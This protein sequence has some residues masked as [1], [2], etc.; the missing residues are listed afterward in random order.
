MK[1]IKIVLLIC[2]TAM[3]MACGSSSSITKTT[4]QEYATTNPN[5]VEIFMS[6]KPSKKYTEIGIVSTLRIKSKIF[7]LDRPSKK[8][9]Q[10]MKEKASSIGGHAIIDYRESGEANMTGTV[11]RY[12]E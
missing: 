6:T 11:I 9:M 2:V 10:A 12:T 8:V 7:P 5:S 4:N 1:N 3:F